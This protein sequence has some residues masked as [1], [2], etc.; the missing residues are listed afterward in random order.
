VE[1]GGCKEGGAKRGVQ[2][3]GRDERDR[4]GKVM[5]YGVDADHD[6]DDDDDDDS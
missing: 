1:R 3:G 4:V 2:R 6:D 5:I